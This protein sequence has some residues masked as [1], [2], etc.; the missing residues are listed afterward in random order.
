ML[1]AILSVDGGAREVSKTSSV[2]STLLDVVPDIYLGGHER[3][4]THNSFTC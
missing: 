2:S 1:G 3:L 4:F